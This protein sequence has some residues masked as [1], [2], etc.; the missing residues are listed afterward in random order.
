MRHY[1]PTSPTEFE[2]RQLAFEFGTACRFVAKI[3]ND[4]KN[5]LKEWVFNLFKPVLPPFTPPEQLFLDLNS[6][7]FPQWQKT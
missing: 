3:V 6:S 4:A 5:S 1:K 2:S 7:D